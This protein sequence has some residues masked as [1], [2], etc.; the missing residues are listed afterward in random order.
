MC[1]PQAPSCSGCKKSCD[2]S[3]PRDAHAAED[4]ASLYAIAEPQVSRQVDDA[5]GLECIELRL[6]RD[7][8]TRLSLLA[9]ALDMPV[10][11]LA[12]EI[13]V[14]RLDEVPATVPE[15]P[16]PVAPAPAGGACGYYLMRPK[17]GGEVTI[18]RRAPDSWELR[19]CVIEWVEERNAPPAST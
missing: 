7:V 1:Q 18:V 10:Q 8:L 12:R 15:S 4:G 19:E 16:L 9:D 13:L 5:L 2:P 14:R 3:H 11:A 6:S 17:A